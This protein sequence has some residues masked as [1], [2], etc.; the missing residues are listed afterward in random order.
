AWPTHG[1][2]ALTSFTKAPP[3]SPISSTRSSSRNGAA[4][5]RRGRG[6]SGTLILPSYRFQAEGPTEPAPRQSVD[7]GD[8]DRAPPRATGDDV[9]P[10]A[11]RGHEA[12]RRRHDALGHGARR[13]GG[14]ERARGAEVA[15]P[16]AHRRHRRAPV[17][18]GGHGR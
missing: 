2:A 15:D 18:R 6:S 16:A 9:E 11:R 13:G 4:C 14:G 10:L 3:R 12:E 5:G 8:P 17:E 1:S 7:E